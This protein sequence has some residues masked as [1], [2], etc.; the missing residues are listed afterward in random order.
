MSEARPRIPQLIDEFICLQSDGQ[1][2]W[3]LRDQ[4]G[5]VQHSEALYLIECLEE[6]YAS[7]SPRTITIWNSYPKKK[8]PLVGINKNPIPGY[9]YL[10][11]EINGPHYKI[12]RSVNPEDRT[13]TFGIKLPY[14][15]E[16]E[17]LIPTTDMHNLEAELHA[18][19]A[20]KRVDG[21]WFAL[22]PA[23]VDY[24]KSLAVEHG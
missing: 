10:I 14:K 4:S 1:G 20:D 21:E 9:V 3:F 16:Y 12:G 22:E 18:R 2:H 5:I 11:N 23:D 7:V 24:I 19:F 17:A 8:Y 13:K 6:F 15:I